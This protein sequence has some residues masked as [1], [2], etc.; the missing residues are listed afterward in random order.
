MMPVA[1]LSAAATA[2]ISMSSTAL[3]VA[4]T[5]AARPPV[6]R[7]CLY[8]LMLAAGWRRAVQ[9][10]LGDVLH[11]PV[12]NQIPDRLAE[13][14]PRPARGGRDGQRR[15][16]DQAHLPLRQAVTGEPVPRTRTAYEMRQ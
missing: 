12:R 5:G 6:A 13:R 8:T 7:L 10:S 1:S 11:D 16:L 14:Y 2:A 9:P 15:D 4:V 3:S